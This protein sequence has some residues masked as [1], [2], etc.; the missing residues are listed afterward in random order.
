MKKGFSGKLSI[1]SLGQGRGPT[2]S[3][4]VKNAKRTGQWVYL[5]NCH[6]C[7]SFLPTLELM[8]QKMARKSQKI[9]SDFRLI[10]SSMPTDVFPIAV[11]RNSVKVT[12]EP[13]R[14]IQPNVMLLLNTLSPDQWEKCGKIRPWKKL[15]FS[16]ALFQATIQERK[17]YGA[18]GFNKTY[19]W[20][21]SDFSIA[22]K[23]LHT[24][25]SQNEFT[26]WD[27]LRQMIGDV[28]Y[29]GR[30]TDD[31]DRRCMNAVLDR[32]LCQDALNDN[33]F[34]DSD[35]QYA[36]IPVINFDQLAGHIGRF[37]NEDAPS[38]FGFHPSALNALQ[39][40]QSNQMIAWV[41][42]VQPRESGGSAAQRDD[43]TVL[44]IAEDL[45]AQ[46][47]QSISTKN[48]NPAIFEESYTD[49]PNSLTVVLLQETERYNRLLGIIHGSLRSVAQAI[50]GEVVMSIDNAEVYRSLLDRQVPGAWRSCS[51]PS[52]KP[53][54]SWFR[55]LQERVTFIQNWLRKG[56]PNVFW[57]PGF[58]FPQ[59]FLTAVLQNHSRKYSVP[60]D[61][62]TFEAKIIN[63][64]IDSIVHPADDGAYITGLYFDGACWDGDENV[65]A[66]AAANTVYTPCPIVQIVPS[67]EFTHPPEDYR[68]PV[69]RTAERAGVLSTTGHSTN[70]VV[71]LNLPTND[72][73]NKWTLRGTA[74]LL[75]TPY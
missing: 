49:R 55:D 72:P 51:Y 1:L 52:M 15:L 22:V 10:L 9:H 75:G 34:F 56:P 30:V 68:C 57:F 31:W 41:L 13:P 21:T 23:M 29:G 12:S 65:L 16:I 14:G 37:P 71:A 42:G 2:A 59:S 45:A 60:I 70:F 67:A 44:T 35:G 8:I 69:Y 54:A 64:D 53:L 7:P 11:L 33:I 27:A 6:L 32:F 62:L 28:V 4:L 5:Q 19:E 3:R 73:P 48:A 50:R 17:R 74:L 40:H 43:D 61:K 46:L 47:P 66:D 36:Q 39:L 24:Y 20:N 58:F 26:P 38:I 18:L 25:L 63:E